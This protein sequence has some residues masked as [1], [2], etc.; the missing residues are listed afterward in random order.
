M[1][2]ILDRAKFYKSTNTGS[3][4]NK[5]Y[6]RNMLKSNTQCSLLSIAFQYS[7]FWLLSAYKSCISQPI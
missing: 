6:T 3:V 7:M 1:S 2:H 5:I 4:L